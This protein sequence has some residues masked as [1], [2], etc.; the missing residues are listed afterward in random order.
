MYV[1]IDRQK[2]R[3]LIENSF[4]NYFFFPFFFSKS[5]LKPVKVI[6][7]IIICLFTNMSSVQTFMSK[8]LLGFN[9]IR[10]PDENNNFS[11]FQ[12]ISRVIFFSKA[13]LVCVYVFVCVQPF[14]YRS[15]IR[16]TV[17]HFVFLCAAQAEM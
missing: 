14:P 10:L 6:I 16:Y 7:K 3:K 8:L 17:R 9:D 12:L 13:V 11:S 1:H 5:D 2:Q 4:L 15:V